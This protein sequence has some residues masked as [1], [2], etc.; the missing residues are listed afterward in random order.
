MN[1]DTIVI[2]STMILGFIGI[3]IMLVQTS[4]QIR[5]EIKELRQEIKSDMNTLEIKLTSLYNTLL[6]LFLQKEVAS[7]NLPKEEKT[8]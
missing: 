1:T 2:I 3:F 7:R 6:N 4:N 8:S 5:T